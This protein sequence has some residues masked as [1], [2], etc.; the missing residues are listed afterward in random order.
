[1]KILIVDDS[2]THRSHL[3]YVF[4]TYHHKILRAKNGK[5]AITQFKRYK[6]DLVIIDTKMPIMDGPT[7][8]AE[9][10]AIDPRALIIGM[11]MTE[12]GRQYYEYFWRKDEPI[13]KLICLG[14]NLLAKKSP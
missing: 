4:G 13:E 10:K 12:D 2:V 1:M 8:V 6:P 5:T 9:I 14:L 7:L 11:A 3:S